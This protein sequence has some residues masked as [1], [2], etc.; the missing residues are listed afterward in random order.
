MIFQH[1]ADSKLG[2]YQ[3]PAE[4][5]LQRLRTTHSAR[6]VQAQCAAVN[7]EWQAFFEAE[8]LQTSYPQAHRRHPILLG[9][10]AGTYTVPGTMDLAPCG[11][12]G[13]RLR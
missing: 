11:A 1:V 13:V 10:L 7:R 2:P 4:R 12:P 8:K 3:S 5:R 6:G 9:R